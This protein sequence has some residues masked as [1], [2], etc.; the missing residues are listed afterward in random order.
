[1]FRPALQDVLFAAALVLA[2][3]CSLRVRA[4]SD[5]ARATHVAAPSSPAM[6]EDSRVAQARSHFVLGM[7]LFDAGSF[8]DA[9]QE[10]RL[11]ETL[12]PSAEV[13]FNIGRAHE[14]LG[15]YERAARALDR[16]LRDRV[17]AKDAVAVRAHILELDRLASQSREQ[18]Q[19]G[20]QTGSLRIH[21]QSKQALVLV[22]GQRL[23]RDALD[24]P[25]LLTAGRHRLD[26]SQEQ[27]IP[28][29][30][31]LD[32]QAGLLTAAYAD[33]QPVTRSRMRAPARGFSWTLLALAGAGAL[34]S[35]ALGSVAMLQQSR[36]H[37]RQA[38]VWAERTDVALVGTAV[39]ALA[40]AVLYYVEG[41][42]A[43]TELSRAGEQP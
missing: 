9:L 36:G 26:V 23:S 14:E 6:V 12:A 18:S 27:H 8:R 13:W 31:Q 33:L 24:Q 30:A 41:R 19:S 37:T 34:T 21:I 3:T 43:R 25:L 16:Y 7:Q 39:C 42:S 35:G 4:Q 28:M 1:M 29:H 40:A 2:A 10:F 20:S 38:E 11:V 32:V 5:S 17:D 22:D 15:E